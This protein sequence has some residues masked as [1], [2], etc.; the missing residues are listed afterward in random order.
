ME[1]W[2]NTGE[3]VGDAM[4]LSDVCLTSLGYIGSKSR[5]ERS[6]KTEIGTEVSHVTRDS[7]TTFKVKRSRS[8]GRFTH[9]HVKASGSCSGQ[10]GNVLLC[11]GRLGGVRRFGAH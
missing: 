5:T 1:S 8:P 6:R 11:F 3:F 10:R 7:D 4:L 9:R 2:H